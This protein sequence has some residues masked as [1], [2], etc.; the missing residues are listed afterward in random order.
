MLRFSTL[1]IFVLDTVPGGFFN[2][3]KVGTGIRDLLNSACILRVEMANQLAGRRR[4]PE[5]S[6]TNYIARA[7]RLWSKT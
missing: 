2:S 6:R 3:T 1:H 4:T 7:Q 5:G